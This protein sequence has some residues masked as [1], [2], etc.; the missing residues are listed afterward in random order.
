MPFQVGDR[1]RLTGRG[2]SM[3]HIGYDRGD[4][5]TIT[6]MGPRYAGSRDIYARIPRYNQREGIVRDGLTPETS[7]YLSELPRESW[8]AELVSPAEAEPSLVFNLGMAC[9][10]AGVKDV[11]E[12][13]QAIRLYALRDRIADARL[14]IENA[15]SMIRALGVM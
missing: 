13:E 8:G 14:Y 7:Y 12:L 2:W 11:G 6:S 5:V 10:Q 15:R 1:V 3:S 4:I 9:L